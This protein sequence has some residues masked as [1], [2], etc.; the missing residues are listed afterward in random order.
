MLQ[1]WILGLSIA[2]NVKSI[3]HLQ[4]VDDTLLLGGSSKVI[5]R[6]FK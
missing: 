6:F 3:H 1:E 4:F 5:A 2:R